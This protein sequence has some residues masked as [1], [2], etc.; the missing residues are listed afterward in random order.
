MEKAKESPLLYQPAMVLAKLAKTKTQTRR[1][2]KVKEG[3]EFAELKIDENS[4]W[5]NFLYQ[6]KQQIELP[7][8]QAVG[9]H[10]GGRPWM[11]IKFPKGNI[12]D[13][14]WGRERWAVEAGWDEIKP[15]EMPPC[16]RTGKA[17]VPSVLIWYS[18]EIGSSKEIGSK[19]YH[20]GKV[21]PSIFMPRQYSR[22][23]DQIVNVRVQRILDISEHDAQ[24]EGFRYQHGKTA[25]QNLIEYWDLI[26]PQM[27]VKNN[28]YV[29]VIE[30]KE[31]K[32]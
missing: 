13:Y 20:H 26:N 31:I 29:W 11:T 17:E 15:S 25:R 23:Y 14:I 9:A 19:I 24:A 30:T 6:G 1:I 7:D 22:I 16:T 8:G 27:P 28:P 5:A 2:I 21:R 10:F 3:F 18:D 12:G 4:I 32:I